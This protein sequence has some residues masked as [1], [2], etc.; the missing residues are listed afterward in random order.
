M[1]LDSIR[2]HK[3]THNL[4]YMT[5][6]YAKSYEK[7]E[8]EAER[9]REREPHLCVSRRDP[10]VGSIILV[11]RVGGVSADDVDVAG[12]DEREHLLASPEGLWLQD[13]WLRHLTV[14]TGQPHQ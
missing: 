3:C 8:M 6:L 13:G 4:M 11:V 10:L 1:T 14:P 5:C 12:Y 9:E 2:M 7:S